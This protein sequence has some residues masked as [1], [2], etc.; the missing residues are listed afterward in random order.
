MGW[1]LAVRLPPVAP[2][3]VDPVLPGDRPGE[4]TS[5]SREA[6]RAAFREAFQQRRQAAQMKG[7]VWTSGGADTR[8]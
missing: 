4:V 1:T 3:A 7:S 5:R 6:F 2:N 8:S